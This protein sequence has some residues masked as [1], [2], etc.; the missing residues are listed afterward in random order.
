MGQWITRYDQSGVHTSSIPAESIAAARGATIVLTSTLPRARA[1]ALAVG[2]AAARSDALFCEAQLPFPL[3]RFPRLAPA[4]WAVLFRVSW[5]CGYTRG[6]ES[7][8]TIR[9]RATAASA[10]LIA[11]AADGPVL[12]VGHGIMNRL[13][14]RELRA[15]GWIA[16]GRQRSGY[17]ATTHYHCPIPDTP[18]RQRPPHRA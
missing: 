7:L 18:V 8:A 10:Q 17:W 15:A 6:V 11:C 9:L 4:V 12:L 3:W 13:I 14:A 16:T 1:S 2:H 5:M